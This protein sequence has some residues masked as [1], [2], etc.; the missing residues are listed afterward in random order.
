M[1]DVITETKK[2]TTTGHGEHY[3]YIHRSP[4]VVK[5]HHSSLMRPKCS[6]TFML[7]NTLHFS[8]VADHLNNFYCLGLEAIFSSY[9]NDTGETNLIHINLQR[10]VEKRILDSVHQSGSLTRET[11]IKLNNS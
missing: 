7:I 8:S 11:G 1:C 3:T 10:G 6:T 2:T 5:G 4:H 9:S